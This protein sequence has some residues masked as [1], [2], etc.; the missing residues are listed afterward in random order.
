MPV[1]EYNCDACGTTTE[2]LRRMAHADDPQACPHC[3]HADTRRRQSVFA[4]GAGASGSRGERSLPM[5]GG[6]GCAC[7]DPMGPCNVR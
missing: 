4:A 7:G 1:Y 3:G 6:G 2:T 5:A